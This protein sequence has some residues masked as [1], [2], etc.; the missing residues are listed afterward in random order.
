[1]RPPTTKPKPS[2]SEP[3]RGPASPPMD[4]E[5]AKSRWRRWIDGAPRPL[6]I[7]L[8]ALALGGMVLWAVA[9]ATA[10]IDFHLLV[11]ALWATPAGNI[12]AALAATG[13]SYLSLVGYDICGLRYARAWAP[14]RTILLASFCGFAIGNSVGLGAFSGGAVRFRLYAAAGLSPG[15]IARVILFISV[16]IGVGLAS[17]AGLGLLLHATEVG[18][19]IGAPPGL[20]HAIAAIVLVLVAGFLI[21]C[22]S[23]KTPL[24]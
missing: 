19:L 20:L 11:S 4:H 5:G 15:E 24:R 17:V 12:A 3:I 6:L 22:A 9:R 8:G 7:A 21:I 18:P 16:A 2:G 1:M 14:L 23:R 10:Q 13:L